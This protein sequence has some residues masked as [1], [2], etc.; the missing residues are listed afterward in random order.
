MEPDVDLRAECR[1]PLS[2]PILTATS[3]VD[4]PLPGFSAETRSAASRRAIVSPAL[5]ARES[6]AIRN[7]HWCHRRS[8]RT[9]KRS[10]SKRHYFA[11]HA[12]NVWDVRATAQILKPARL[13]RA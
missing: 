8:L 9:K 13:P 3:T 12:L 6:I 4:L 1:V 10:R 11:A 7:E 2:E 5:L